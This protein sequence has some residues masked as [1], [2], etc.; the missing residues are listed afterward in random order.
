VVERAQTGVA[1]SRGDCGQGDVGLWWFLTANVSYD[2]RRPAWILRRLMH[3]A[4]S[5][6]QV[7]RHFVSPQDLEWAIYAISN[8]QFKLQSR[9]ITSLVASERSRTMRELERAASRQ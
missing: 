8:P 3:C 5:V 1:F 9:A 7:E 4:V 2:R 6:T